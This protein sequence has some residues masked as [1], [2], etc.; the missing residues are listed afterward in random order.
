MLDSLQGLTAA[1]LEEEA[2]EEIVVDPTVVSKVDEPLVTV[3]TRGDVVAAVDDLDPP[4][5]AP[6][7]PEKVV[8]PVLVKVDLSLVP[9]VVKVLV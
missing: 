5:A 6:P 1:P 9:V 8:V 3:E 7:L 2:A 4:P